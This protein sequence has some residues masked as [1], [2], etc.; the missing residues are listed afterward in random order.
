MARIVE[1]NGY[2]TV[3]GNQR[4]IP[5]SIAYPCCL[6][7]RGGSLPQ[8]PE[9]GSDGL[10]LTGRVAVVERHIN[11]TRIGQLGHVVMGCAAKRRPWILQALCI[12][13]ID[14][15]DQPIPFDHHQYH[16]VISV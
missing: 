1:G 6:G 12:D 16:M 10:A 7:D 15:R 8:P 4:L 9:P 5:P 11:P 13:R 2:R 3:R 14:E